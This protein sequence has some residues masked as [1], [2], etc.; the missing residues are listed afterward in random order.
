[1]NKKT[2]NRVMNTRNRCIR[3]LEF[4]RNRMCSGVITAENL[5]LGVALTNAVHCI[6]RI[7]V[8]R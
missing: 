5:A 7:L 1:M 2:R 6:E 4:L 8:Q 3:D